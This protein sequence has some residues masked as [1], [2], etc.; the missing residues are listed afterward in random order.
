MPNRRLAFLPSSAMPTVINERM[1]SG[2][3]KDRKVENREV[4]VA[5]R[6]TTAI[7]AVESA[8]PNQPAAKA[9]Q[10]TGNDADNQANKQSELFHVNFLLFFYSITITITRLLPYF[11]KSGAS[12]GKKIKIPLDNRERQ[13][14]NIITYCKR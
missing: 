12:A 9:D 14:A 11:R 4:N 1:I 7:N 8:M 10:R 13:S 2:I 5:N 6:R 3:M